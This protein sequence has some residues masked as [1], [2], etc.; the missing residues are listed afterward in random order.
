MIRNFVCPEEWIEVSAVS[1]SCIPGRLEDCDIVIRILFRIRARSSF[2]ARN[3]LW[4]PIR[5]ISDRFFGVMQAVDIPF[6]CL[7][8]VD[9][10]CHCQPAHVPPTRATNHT[11]VRRTTLAVQLY[12]LFSSISNTPT[13]AIPS[14]RDKSTKSGALSDKVLGSK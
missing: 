9:I 1:A 11:A 3:S 13:T 4:L 14:R 6:I 8:K 5:T 7:C 12:L 2:G 10:F